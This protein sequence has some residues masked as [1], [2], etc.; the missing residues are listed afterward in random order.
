MQRIDLRDLAAGVVRALDSYDRMIQEIRSR[1]GDAS[2]FTKKS[3]E[4]LRQKWDLQR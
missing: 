4:L 1:G 2:F 3:E